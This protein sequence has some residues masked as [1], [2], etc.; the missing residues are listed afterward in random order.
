M[1]FGLPDA[2]RLWS[3]RVQRYFYLFLK[4]L[5]VMN[6]NVPSNRIE[7]YPARDVTCCGQLELVILASATPSLESWVNAGKLAP[8]ALWLLALPKRI[9]NAQHHMTN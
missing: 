7:Q 9:H 8:S 1:R 4:G 6:M 2:H 5:I 3:V